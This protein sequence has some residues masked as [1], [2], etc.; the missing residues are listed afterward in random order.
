LPHY[1]QIECLSEQASL[2]VSYDGWKPLTITILPENKANGGREVLLPSRVQEIE[3]IFH[4][5]KDKRE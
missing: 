4:N 2:A 3:K 5:V 1:L